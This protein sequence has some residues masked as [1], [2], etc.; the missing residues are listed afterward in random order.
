MLTVRGP[1]TDTVLDMTRDGV[2][3][4]AEQQYHQ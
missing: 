2:A 4:Y 3:L 1:D